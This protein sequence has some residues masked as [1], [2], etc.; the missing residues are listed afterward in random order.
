[1]KKEVKIEIYNWFVTI[2]QNEIKME[3]EL[4]RRIQLDQS[5]LYGQNFIKI[6]E[7]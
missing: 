5:I 3:P 1:V 6:E 4:M 7:D 2:F